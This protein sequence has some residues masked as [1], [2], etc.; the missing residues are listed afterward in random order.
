MRRAILYEKIEDN[1]V[2]CRLCRH[3]CTV[4]PGK[5]GI[6]AVRINEGGELYTLVYD[7]V[8][9]ASADPIEKK[10][11]FHFYPG[12]LAFSVSTMGCNFSCRHCQNASLSKTPSETGVIDGRALSPQKIVERALSSGCRSISYTYTE[13]TI[14]AELALETARLAHSEGLANNF[15][16]NGYQSPGM[17]AEMKGLIDAANVDLKSFSPHF[18]KEICGAR[19]DGVID[20]IHLL[21]EAGLWLEITTLVIPT[22]NDSDEDLRDVAR[23]IAGLD[24]NIP[25]HVSRFHPAYLMTGLPP[26]PAST[27][28]RAREIG[29]EE[30]LRYVYTGNIPGQGGED[31]HCPGC[32]ALLIERKGFSLGRNRVRKSRCPDCGGAVAG[33]FEDS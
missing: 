17:V 25:W 19:L 26:T 30:G 23:F 14:F 20:T 15:V 13:P 18:Y 6:C 21:H 3:G 32:D 24:R 31:T 22:K 2:R 7:R 12:S 8:A 10:P 28:F 27:L 33:V 9:A 1:K 11:L 29:L 5:T 16:T 4:S